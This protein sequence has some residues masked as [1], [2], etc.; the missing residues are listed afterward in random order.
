MLLIFPMENLNLKET[1]LQHPKL[2]ELIK[3]AEQAISFEKIMI[4]IWKLIAI[5]A[6]CVMEEIL[7]HRAQATTE[8]PLCPVCGKRLE[9]KGFA[10]RQLKT[11]FGVVNWK[12]RVGRCPNR[13]EIGQVVPLD[14]ALGLKPYQATCETVERIACLLAVFLPFKIAAFL[15][16]QCLNLYVSAS[17]L[18]YWTQSAGSVAMEELGQEL[19]QLQEGKEPSPEELSEKVSRMKLLIGGDGVM[20]PF[21]PTP[22]TPAGKTQWQEIKVGILA[23]LTK[24]VTRAGKTVS[25]LVHKRVTAVLGD[26]TEFN[27]RLKLEAL[28]QSIIKAPE[29]VWISDG[30]RGLWNIFDTT[31]ALYAIGILDFYHAT[32]NLWKGVAAWLD[33]RTNQAREW[34]SKARHDLR[35]GQCDKVINALKQAG[36][37]TALS[38]E[39]KDTLRQV[40]A[41]L[42]NHQ[43]HMDYQRFKDIGLPIGSGFVESTCKWL[44][45]QRFKG[46]GMRWSVDGFNRLL[47]L[48]L[49]YINGRFDSI[50]KQCASPN[51]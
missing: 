39:V 49:A 34:F 33:G 23:R 4:A 27:V 40:I 21:R 5:V 1:F 12:R 14:E 28:R 30:A 10:P 2:Q 6:V 26:I 15:V 17:S 16:Q 35:H 44:I 51:H 20:V 42:E 18:W 46:V 50:F 31:F 36:S 43:S 37:S 19:K 3:E 7:R 48:R 8:W 9:S 32:Q 24:R 25:V 38:D 47:H 45:Q 13:C 41:Y 11:I 22:E 29:V